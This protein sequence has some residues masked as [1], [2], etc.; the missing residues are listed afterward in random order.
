MLRLNFDG[1]ENDD[2]RPDAAV[3]AAC[4]DYV[5]QQGTVT[6]IMVAIERVLVEQPQPA[7][8]GREERQA[9][10]IQC[11]SDP[12]FFYGFVRSYSVEV[13]KRHL[14]DVRWLRRVYGVQ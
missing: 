3:I 9:A 11:L 5:F 2:A 10:L 1:R 13:T 14:D 7:W 8:R 12:D 6:N 4:Y